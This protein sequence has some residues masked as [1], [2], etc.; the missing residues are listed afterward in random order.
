MLSGVRVLL[1]ACLAL[2]AL[3][4]TLLL[5]NP[6]SVLG[7]QEPPGRSGPRLAQF[8]ARRPN[9]VLYALVRNRELGALL[10]TMQDMERNFNDRPDTR[11]PYV[12][13]LMELM[14]VFLNDEPFTER[15]KRH[16]RG[17]TRAPVYFGQVPQADWAV[18][19][20]VNMS[21]AQANWEQMRAQGVLYAKSQSYR[22]MCRYQSGLFLHHEL[23]QPYDYYWRLEPGVSYYCHMT[24]NDPFRVMRDQNKTYG[25]V[26]SLRDE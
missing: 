4:A 13:R 3:N 16:V 23:M 22:Q 20:S 6:N 12:G 8:L 10:A 5:R 11:Y 14:Q 26:L 9:A 2:L 25:W 24:D 19:A 1:V 21:R 18:P 15:F 17:A 7:G